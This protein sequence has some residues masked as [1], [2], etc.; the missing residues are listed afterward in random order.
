M[1]RRQL[2]YALMESCIAHADRDKDGKNTN[3]D[4]WDF[5]AWKALDKS[6]GDHQLHEISDQIAAL[7]VRKNKSYGDSFRKCGEVLRILYPDGVKTEQYTDMAA[8]VRIIDKL[9]RIASN[10]KDAFGESPYRDIA[11]YGLL[12]AWKDEGEE[13]LEPILVHGCHSNKGGQI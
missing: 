7:T 11:G 8:V 1:T 6:N 10:E 5:F 2:E 4:W 13:E 3:E 9:F 12:G